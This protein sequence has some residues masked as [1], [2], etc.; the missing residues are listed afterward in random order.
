[1][2]DLRSIIREQFEEAAEVHLVLKQSEKVSEQLGEWSK[3]CANALANGGTIFFAGNGGSFADAQHMAAELTG[4]MGRMRKS[5]S[6]IALG[7]NNSSISAV[8]NDFGYEYS[9]SREFEGLNR[10]NSV[11]VA[12][13]T[14]GNSKNLLELAKTAARLETPMVGLTGD[15]GGDLSELCEVIRLPSKRTERVQEMQTLLGHTLCLCIEEILGLS[16]E[17]YGV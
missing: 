1:M 6:G 5:L 14:S 4:K 12:F 9:F 2:V 10:Q 17:P 7:A 16:D 13:S 3:K 11:V 15:T 8:G